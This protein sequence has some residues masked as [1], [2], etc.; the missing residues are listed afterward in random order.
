MSTAFISAQV[1]DMDR[2][3]EKW[4][5]LQEILVEK[6]IHKHIILVYFFEVFP[7][8]TSEYYHIILSVG[9]SSRN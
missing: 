6:D 7:I 8:I 9:M 3:H 5:L 1:S 4:L 2:I